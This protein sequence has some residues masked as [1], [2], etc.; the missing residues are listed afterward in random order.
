MCEA[1][2]DECS[3]SFTFHTDMSKIEVLPQGNFDIYCPLICH[4]IQ[5]LR[6]GSNRVDCEA[7]YLLSDVNSSTSDHKRKYK[8]AGNRVCIEAEVHQQ[9]KSPSINCKQSCCHSN[10]NGHKAY[11]KADEIEL[12]HYTKQPSLDG[13]VVVINESKVCTVML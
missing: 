6:L 12:S 2:K 4:K 11:K 3:L 5:L 1:L 10:S 7:P 13:N 8:F 9:K